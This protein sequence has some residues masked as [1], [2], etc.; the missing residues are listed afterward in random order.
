MSMSN[1]NGPRPDKQKDPSALENAA[2]VLGIFTNIGSVGASFANAFAA[3]APTAPSPD[4]DLATL[5][6]MQA[7]ANAVVPD[8]PSYQVDQRPASQVISDSISHDNINLGPKK[9]YSSANYYNPSPF[10]SRF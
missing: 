8:V 2:K 4:G 1:V 6:R 7:D 3:K 5:G 9:T 10:N